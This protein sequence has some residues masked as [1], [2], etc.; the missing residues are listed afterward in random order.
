MTRS[1]PLTFINVNV[2][3]CSYHIPLPVIRKYKSKKKFHPTLT[4]QVHNSE[5][6]TMVNLPTVIR[7]KIKLGS[8]W[9]LT[10]IDKLD[11]FFILEKS[12]SVCDILQFLGTKVWSTVDTTE[13]LTG[14]AFNQS[15][16][17]QTIRQVK[18]NVRHNLQNKRGKTSH[19][20]TSYLFLRDRL[21]DHISM[22]IDWVCNAHAY[23]RYTSRGSIFIGLF[24]SKKGPI[25]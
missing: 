12:Q 4:T 9:I 19:V 25:Y 17:V 3:S 2:W 13:F 5:N 7:L 10:N 16:Q 23:L 15:D 22:V 11:S 6:K 20:F 18:L 8:R 21:C 14:E 24:S 1:L